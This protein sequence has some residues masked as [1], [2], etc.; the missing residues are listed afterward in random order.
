[1]R[2]SADELFDQIVFAVTHLLHG[3]SH[4]VHTVYQ[5][6]VAGALR[7]AGVDRMI[8]AAFAR[9]SEIEPFP[10]PDVS[11]SIDGGSYR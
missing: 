7:H 2:D 10:H 9:P 11:P 6:V 4:A 8:Q 1:M 3:E 5:R